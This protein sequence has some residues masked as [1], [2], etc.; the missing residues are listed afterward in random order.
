MPFQLI[1]YAPVLLM[2]VVGLMSY[3]LVHGM[4]GYRQP[5]KVSGA[6]VK[7]ISGMFGADLPKD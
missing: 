5:H 6:V 4:W 2:F 1:D 3:E 7:G